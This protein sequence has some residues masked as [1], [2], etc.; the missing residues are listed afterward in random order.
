M[1]QLLSSPRI[2]VNAKTQ[3][4]DTALLWAS[5]FGHTQIVS[6]LIEAKADPTIKNSKGDNP[7]KL[8]ANDQ[9]ANMLGGKKSNK[10]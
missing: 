8:A 1:K 4:G 9:I 2:D 3:G 10:S 7:I 5:S 6:L